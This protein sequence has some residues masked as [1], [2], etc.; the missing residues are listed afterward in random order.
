MKKG[1][2]LAEVLITLGIIGVVAAITIPNLIANYQKKQ[3]VTKLQKAISVINQAYKLAY[4]E[5]GE[6]TAEEAKSLR[7][8]EYF[9]QYWAPYIKASLICTTYNQWGFKNDNPYIGRNNKRVGFDVVAPQARAAFYTPDGF[10]FNIAVY[11]AGFTIVRRYIV[12]DINGAEAPNML[13]KDVFYLTRVTTDG[14]GVRPLGFDKADAEINKSCSKTG[15]GEYCAEKIRRAGW[16]IDS[17]YPW[18]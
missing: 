5:V 6:P 18:K 3:T 14:G 10:L 11:D 16:R 15:Y 17:S 9:S 1:F 7:A 4:D 12:L 2:T 13:G 8:P